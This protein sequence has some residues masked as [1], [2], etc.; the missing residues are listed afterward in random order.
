MTH[1]AGRARFDPSSF[2]QTFLHVVAHQEGFYNAS[3]AR[4]ES[5]RS[6]LVTVKGHRH[7]LR[8]PYG[9]T[10]AM[11]DTLRAQLRVLRAAGVLS[12]DVQD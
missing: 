2:Q 9:E 12:A 7:T 4:D 5:D 6:C 11:A 1:L 10:T 8:I 3:V